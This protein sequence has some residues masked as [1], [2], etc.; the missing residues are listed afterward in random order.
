MS[1]VIKQSKSQ[2][3]FRT[4]YIFHKKIKLNWQNV[5]VLTGIISVYYHETSLLNCF[6]YIAPVKNLWEIK[7]RQFKSDRKFFPRKIGKSWRPQNPCNWKIIIVQKLFNECAHSWQGFAEII[8]QVVLFT[9]LWLKWSLKKHCLAKVLLATWYIF[10]HENNCN[11]NSYKF[12][13]KF[14]FI[15]ILSFRSQ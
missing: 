7:L 4:F 5:I 3:S 1:D 14:A 13:Y 2:L 9:V 15:P 12:G 10:L 6:L 8:L 11:H